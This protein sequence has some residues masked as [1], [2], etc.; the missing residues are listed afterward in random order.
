MWLVIEDQGVI[1]VERIV[2]VGVVEAAPIRRLLNLT[3]SSQ[4]IVLTGGQ[5]RQSAVI[6]DSGHI[7]LTALTV[8][9]IT[10]ALNRLREEMRN[11]KEIR[12]KK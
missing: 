11:E 7:V 5:K 12:K 10:R 3:P 6:L 2:A 8:A 9:D 4:V 1:A